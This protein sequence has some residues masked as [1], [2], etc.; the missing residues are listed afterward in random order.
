[1]STSGRVFHLAGLPGGLGLA[2]DDAGVF[3]AGTPLLRKTVRGFEPW[4]LDDLALFLRCAYSENRDASGVEAGLVLAAQALNE[5]DLGRATIA[6]LRLRPHLPEV[7]REGARRLAEVVGAWS[8][9]DPNEP[10]DGGPRYMRSR[11]F[12]PL[13]PDEPE[14]P[15]PEPQSSP[16]EP[17]TKADAP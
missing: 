6:A 17:D 12:I 15:S 10:R 7:S 11:L 14:Q 5:G 9:H 13:L 4:P 8:K 1:M 3:L 16:D 2:C